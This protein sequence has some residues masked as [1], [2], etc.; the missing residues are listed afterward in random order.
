MVFVLDGVV[1]EFKDTQTNVF[2]EYDVYPFIILI[3]L[4]EIVL[5]KLPLKIPDLPTT[6]ILESNEISDGTVTSIIKSLV[7]GFLIVKENSIV[8][9]VE[10][11]LVV[12]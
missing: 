7:I 1:I 10:T 5:V 2:V 9:E 12:A 3:L 6:V 4:P 8:I 11:V